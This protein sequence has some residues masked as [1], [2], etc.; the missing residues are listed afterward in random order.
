[1][2]ILGNSRIGH[3]CKAICNPVPQHSSSSGSDPVQIAFLIEMHLS[4]DNRIRQILI[5]SSSAW[6]DIKAH[7]E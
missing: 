3:R 6:E 4:H 7:L 2:F 5:L 1:M